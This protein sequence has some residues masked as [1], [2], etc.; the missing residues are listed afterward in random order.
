MWVIGEKS[1]KAQLGIE[2]NKKIILYTPTF[3]DD[4][5]NKAKKH[6]INLKLDLQRL[7]ESIGD[8]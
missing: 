1:Y 3:R 5:I 7:K 2:S 4:E 8:E 6:I